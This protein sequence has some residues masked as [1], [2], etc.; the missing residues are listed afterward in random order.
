MKTANVTLTLPSKKFLNR[1]LA[2]CGDEDCNTR[3]ARQR[4]T[5]YSCSVSFDS[6]GK[7][8]GAGDPRCW[9]VSEGANNLIQQVYIHSF[10]N[11]YMKG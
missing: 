2:V 6:E 4:N 5:C 8:F 7:Q 9:D 11:C 10:E 1:F 3:P